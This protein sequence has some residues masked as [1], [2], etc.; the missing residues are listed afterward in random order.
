MGKINKKERKTFPGVRASGGLHKTK[1]VVH[2]MYGINKKFILCKPVELNFNP[3]FS[4]LLKGLCKSQDFY[5][6]IRY[7]PNRNHK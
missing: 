6:G 4:Q 5:L 1:T 2:N 3:V 7:V